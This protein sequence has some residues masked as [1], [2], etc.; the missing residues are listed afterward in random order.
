LSLI[1]IFS[2]YEINL[3][4]KTCDISFVLSFFALEGLVCLYLVHMI[5][6]KK[7]WVSCFGRSEREIGM[8]GCLE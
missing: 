6:G 7:L 3:C 8:M 2:V 5:V 1:R 4:F